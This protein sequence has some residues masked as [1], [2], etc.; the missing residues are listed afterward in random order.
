LLLM[1]IRHGGAIL[2]ATILL[3]LP[4]RAEASPTY[5]SYVGCSAGGDAAPSH[6]CKLGDQL[7]AFFEV[8]NRTEVQFQTC[9]GRP[10]QRGACTAEQLATALTPL[11]LRF[12]PKLLGSYVVTWFVAGRAVASWAFQS[13]PTDAGITAATASKA[14]REKIL[15]ESPRRPFSAPRGQVLPQGLSG[16]RRPALVLLR[17]VSKRRPLDPSGRHG[18]W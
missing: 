16:R 11:V 4:G 15:L 9:I 14:F 17:R 13:V 6:V 8:K 2:A 12:T 10:G 7:G 18:G 3:L 1:S 5:V